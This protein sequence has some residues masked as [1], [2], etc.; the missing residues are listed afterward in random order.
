VETEELEYQPSINFRSL[1]SLPVA[2]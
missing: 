2:W 1:T